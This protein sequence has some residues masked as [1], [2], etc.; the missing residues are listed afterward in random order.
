MPVLA[1]CRTCSARKYGSVG[2]LPVFRA[3]GGKRV[4]VDQAAQDGVSADLSCV[5]VG[6]GGA[7]SVT[8]IGGDALGDAL[9]R[10]GGVVV[11]LVF[12]Q[13]RVQMPTAEDQH[14]VQYLSAQGADEA[15]AGRVHARR[16]DSGTQDP[17]PAPWN[18]ASNEAVKFDP[19]S[20]MRNLMSSNRSPR[21]RARLRAWV[22]ASGP[23]EDDL[24][25]AVQAALALRC[26]ARDRNQYRRDRDWPW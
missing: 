22:P 13:D 7:E 19:R 17:A 20:R 2:D 21:V 4:F 5:D 23:G 26:L 14:P 1:L 8:F 3:S 25:F 10:T 9:M 24:R 16:L 18:T 11:R 15:L 12:G 6:H